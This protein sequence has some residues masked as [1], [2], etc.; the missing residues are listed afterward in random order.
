MSVAAPGALE[1]AMPATR[2]SGRSLVRVAC[3]IEDGLL[4]VLLALLAL[5]PLTDA[6]LLAAAASLP[7]AGA[8]V[9]HLTLLLCMAGAAVAARADRLLAIGVPSLLF[10]ARLQPLARGLAYSSAAVISAWLAFAGYELAATERRA[11]SVLAFGVPIWAL[12]GAIPAGFAV[13]SLRLIYHGAVRWTMRVVLLALVAIAALLPASD[14]LPREHMLPAGLAVVALAA[15]C[16]TPVFAVIGGFAIVLLW[17][18]GF[19]VAAMAVKHYSLA[20]TPA[21]STIPLFTLAG[22]LLAEGGAARRLVRACQALVGHWRGGPA[23]VTA[24]TC[25]FF[26]CFTGA[27][28]VTILAL[29]GLLLPVLLAT[30]Y[31][32]RAAVGLVTGAGS[33]GLLFPPCL[34]LILY[35]V[36]ASQALEGLGG[37]ASGAFEV[38]IERMLVAGIGPGVLLVGLTAAWGWH[39]APRRTARPVRFDAR[40]AAAALWEA[41]WELAIPFVALGALFGGWL[42][43]PVQAAA[44]TAVYA[45]VIEAFVYRDLRIGRDLVRVLRETGLLA[46]S[47]LLIFGV[48]LGLTNYLVTEQIPDRLIEWVTAAVDSPFVFL[49]ALNAL[50]IVVGCLMDIYSA[51]VIVVPL[52]V[53]L[54]VHFGVDPVHLGIIFLANLELGFVTPPVGMNLFLAAYRFEKPLTEIIRA[55]LPMMLVLLVGVVLITY[56]PLLTLWLPA[57][58]F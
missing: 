7:D 10:P 14:I 31:E 52:I 3:T 11:G 21:I 49:L 38:S 56:W 46:G 34:P 12:E 25:A 47:V 54:A 44:L 26:T 2:S 32:E 40:E 27:S 9:Q 24:A 33:L 29:G 17:T 16:G 19:P 50:L 18:S 8:F 57:R 15:A 5:I 13:I 22:C 37:S 4:G 53:P 45:F 35:A 39:K 36:V 58:L 20:T 6:A 41:K 48:A 51:I 28:G 55:S 23:I 1:R 30:R 42:T 43:S